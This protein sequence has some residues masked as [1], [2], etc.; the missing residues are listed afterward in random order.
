MS[1]ISF[2]HTVTEPQIKQQHTHSQPKEPAPRLVITRWRQNR[3]VGRTTAHSYII[4]IREFA[5]L[6]KQFAGIGSSWYPL[7]C[8]FAAAAAAVTQCSY[9]SSPC[10]PS[11][12]PCGYGKCNLITT[13]EPESSVSVCQAETFASYQSSF[14]WVESRFRGLNWSK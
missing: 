11:R 5:S 1:A 8:S 9:Q 14:I 10:V 6:V 2:A 3:E 7:V 4:I 12:R 13:G